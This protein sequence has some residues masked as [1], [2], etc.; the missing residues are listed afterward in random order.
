M[1]RNTT[2]LKDV[3]RLNSIIKIVVSHKKHTCNTHPMDRQTGK[4][5]T[6]YDIDCVMEIADES[7]KAGT[8]SD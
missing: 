1:N 6:M 7:Y 2:K 4:R 3:Q 5:F 8:S